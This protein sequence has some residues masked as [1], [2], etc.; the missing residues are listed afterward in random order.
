MLSVNIMKEFSG[1]CPQ[2]Q[3][4]ICLPNDDLT[5]TNRMS[6]LSWLGVQPLMKTMTESI[7]LAL[8]GLKTQ[9]YRTKCE[10]STIVSIRN[11]P[12]DKSCTYRS[13]I[14]TIPGHCSTLNWSLGRIQEFL[15]GVQTL[16]FVSCLWKKCE[17]FD[18]SR[19]SWGFEGRYKA[20]QK[21][22]QFGCS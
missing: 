7:P 3:V 1:L 19:S 20:P 6:Y 12:F 22:L 15:W 5:R 14:N 13:Y 11:I 17:L 8:A 4:I 18:R 9:I 2:Q 10:H 21:I 16:D